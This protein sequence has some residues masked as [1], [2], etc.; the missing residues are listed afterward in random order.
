MLFCDHEYILHA[1]TVVMEAEES[2]SDRSSD[3]N[4]VLDLSYSSSSFEGSIGSEDSDTIPTTRA[5]LSSHIVTSRNAVI[6]R[7]LRPTIL[8]I[9]KE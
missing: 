4:S 8:A 2:E 1:S 9:T 6:H 7:R 5:Q 3:G